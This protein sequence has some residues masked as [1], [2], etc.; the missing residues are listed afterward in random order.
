[1]IDNKLNIVYKTLL[2]NSSGD[3]IIDVLDSILEEIK[4]KGIFWDESMDS[5]VPIYRC[6]FCGG[7]DGNNWDGIVEHEKECKYLLIEQL[8]K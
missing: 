8:L 4:D 7:T 3:D 2:N 5:M 6:I 1:M